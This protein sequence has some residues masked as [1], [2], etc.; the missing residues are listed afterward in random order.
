MHRGRGRVVPSLLA[1][2]RKQRRRERG[3]LAQR[4]FRRRQTQAA[5]DMREEN[6]R[7]RAAIEELAELVGPDNRPA[8]RDAVRRAADA[9]GVVVV[10]GG[11]GG[12][13]SSGSG[14]SSSVDC[15]GDGGA[16]GGSS[17]GEGDA[18]VVGTL[19]KHASQG[20]MS[21]SSSSPPST[22]EGLATALPNSSDW[23][24]ALSPS[25]AIGNREPFPYGPASTTTAQ[26]PDPPRLAF[27][28]DRGIW[29]DA[30]SFQR[31]VDPPPDIAPYLGEGMHTLAGH[32]MW[33][34][35]EH[36]IAICQQI[37]AAA[38]SSPL[39]LES[40]LKGNANISRRKT[41][42]LG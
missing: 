41:D 5:R 20:S 17:K 12:G 39:E 8:L 32:V 15:R 2:P 6:R 16:G 23:Q 28:L 7:M 36:I 31:I 21:S 1:T 25:N 30:F 37:E 18:Q 42:R 34:C 38:P 27:S 14:P 19:E 33:A 24:V 11:G 22:S 10:E 13:G 9:A 26:V 35:V 40:A 3:K 29:N 4:A